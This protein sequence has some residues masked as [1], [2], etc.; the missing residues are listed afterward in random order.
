MHLVS[1]FDK[2]LISYIYRASLLNQM[3]SDWLAEKILV[4]PIIMAGM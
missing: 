1:Y 4:I 2:D 3:W